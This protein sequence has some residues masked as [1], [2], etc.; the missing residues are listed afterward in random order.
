VHK[1]KKNVAKLSKGAVPK[2]TITVP[3]EEEKLK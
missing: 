2:T 1:A 3:P